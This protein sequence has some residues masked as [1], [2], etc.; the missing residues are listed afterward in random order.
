MSGLEREYSDLMKE[1][2]GSPGRWNVKKSYVDVAR[3]LGIDEETVRNRLRRLKETGFLV[4]WRL[5]P[6]PA[7]F[8]RA[9]VMQHLTF[10][11][12]VTK[13][14]ALSQ[15][16]HADGVVVVA[17]LYGAD[18]L[19]TLYDDGELS[20]S[21]RL[22]ALGSKS[23]PAEWHGMSLPPTSFRMTP[24]DWRVVSLM[25]RDAEKSVA[26]V[27]AEVRVSM[28][29]VKR[30]LDSMMAAS[31]IFIVPMID[32]AKS[33]GVSYQ[34]LVESEKGRKSEVDRLVTSTI[35]NLVFKTADSSDT[36]IFGFAGKNVAEGKELLDLLTKRPGVK[37]VRINI[38]E[39]VVYVFDWLEREP[40]RL[41]E[42]NDH[43]HSA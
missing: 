13:R 7:L 8:G 5:L 14:D 26:E 19:V 11:S 31:A 39:E 3:N 2:W 43:I 25:L 28:R 20:S 9:S 32:Q 42:V 40:R 12:P 6:N 35:E 33:T 21:R 17:S 36:L 34:V 23:G 10:D 24:T 1:L 41:A 38:V 27:A 18:L 29:T 4:G 16:K 15:S 37:S 22:S 30:R